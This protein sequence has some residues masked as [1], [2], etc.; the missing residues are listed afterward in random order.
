MR[1]VVGRCTFTLIQGTIRFARANRFETLKASRIA[2][3]SVS[4][5]RTRTRE[6]ALT[7]GPDPFDWDALRSGLAQRIRAVRIER[8][9][10][11]G[12]PLLAQSLHIPYREWL[13]YET[14]GMIP[15]QVLLQFIELTQAHPHWLLTGDGEKYRTH[16][17]EEWE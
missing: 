1:A 13:S 15:A 8:F 5:T 4:H 6:L 10:A 17:R 2:Y 14:G 3:L 12:G 16:E 7:R 11:H 9:G